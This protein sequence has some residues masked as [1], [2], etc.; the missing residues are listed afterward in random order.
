M[1]LSLDKLRLLRKQAGDPKAT[2]PAEVETPAVA[3]VP[4][5]ANDARQPPAARSVFAWVEQEIRHKPTGTAAATSAPAPLRRPEVGSL[6]RLLGLRSRGGAVPARASA[7]DRQLPGEEIAPGLFL[8]ESLQ[9]QPIPAASLSLAFAKR[10]NEHVAARDLLFFDTETTGLAGGTG[11]RAFM[12]G[13][14][15]WHACPQRGEGLRIRQLLMATM[16]AEDA[17]LATFASWLQPSTVFCSYNGRSYDAPLLKARY[18]LA[19]QRDPITA[20]DHVDLLY[21]TRRR[22]RGTWE[23]CKLS[24]IERQLLRVMREDDLPGSEAPGAWLRF[25]RGGDAINLR[26]VADHNHQDVV[27]LAL[28]LQRLVHEEQRER[29]TLALVAR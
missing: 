8:I 24:T 14:A 5:A 13:A 25:L 7:Q 11:T 23:N 16:A 9:P 4:A 22:Y 26:R 3:P 19:R 20:L 17:M 12:I 15:D 28:L 6:H 10:E 18:R 2:A 27:T 1:S 21:P 29:E